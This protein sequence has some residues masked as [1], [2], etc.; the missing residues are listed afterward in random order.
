[1]DFTDDRETEITRYESN[2]EIPTAY[3]SEIKV[4]LLAITIDLYDITEKDYIHICL[5]TYIQPR[6][7]LNLRLRKCPVNRNTH[8]I[9]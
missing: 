1:M 5:Y 8:S 7:L 9:L 2:I 6:I 3:Q 4:S